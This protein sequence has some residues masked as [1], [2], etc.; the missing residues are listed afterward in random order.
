[1]AQTTTFEATT[2]EQEFW[3]ADRDQYSVDPAYRDPWSGLLYYPV[4]EA[5]ADRWVIIRQVQDNAD[6]DE[7]PTPVLLGEF[8]DQAVAEHICELILA[9]KPR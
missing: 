3:R 9:T 8:E 7:L 4:S 2:A 6:P 5:K 1:M